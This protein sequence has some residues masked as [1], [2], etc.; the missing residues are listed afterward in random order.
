MLILEGKYNF[1]KIFTGEYKIVKIPKPILDE[2]EKE[3]LHHI[4]RPFTDSIKCITKYG[5]TDWES[6]TVAYYDQAHAGDE[7]YIHFPT[8]KAGTMYKGMKSG[9]HYTLEELGL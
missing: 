5:S 7:Y 8:F 3:Y 4:I 9:K 6:I 2:K 1:C